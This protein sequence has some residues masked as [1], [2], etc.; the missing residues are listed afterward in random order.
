MGRYMVG[1]GA[2]G[3]VF[4]ALMLCGADGGA[5]VCYARGLALEHG[6]DAAMQQDGKV[7]AK[8]EAAEDASMQEE[9][10]RA[11][12][13]EITA[14]QAAALEEGLK[15]SPDNLVAREKLIRYYFRAELSLLE[16][17]MEERRDQHIFWLIEHHPEAQLAGS[18]EAGIESFGYPD[19]AERYQHGKELWLEQA[20][21]QADNAQIL[22]SA[23]QY[24]FL[25]D[26]EAGRKLLEKALAI[27]PGDQRATSMLAMSYAQER[28][29]EESP[30][31][32]TALAE[33]AVLVRERALNNAD[34][35]ERFYALGDL[36]T[37]ELEAGHAARAAQYAQ[38]LLRLAPEFSHNWNYGNALHKA[39]IVLGRIALRDGDIPG[40]KERLLA[41]GKTP[42]SPQLD[43]FGPNMMLAKE[44]LEKGER[45]VIIEYI[46]LCAQFWKMDDSKLKNWKAT[47]KGGGTPDFGANLDY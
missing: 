22:R 39:N 4:L 11:A 43:S 7:A 31:M 15:T 44:L 27:E 23:A 9:G 29:A 42:G 46:D 17:E 6:G 8:Q 28:D 2:V 25:D 36:A 1:L 21:K 10:N 3:G 33:K 12:M 26:R 37:S 18:P 40:A 24:M 14:E 19:S 45:N 47:I 38:E 35:E 20:D 16:P 34:Q 13:Q 41:A 5:H 32:K 30:E